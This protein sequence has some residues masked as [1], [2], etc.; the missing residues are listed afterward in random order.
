[1]RCLFKRRQL[2]LRVEMQLHS[3]GKHQTVE[4]EH[5]GYDIFGHKNL[6]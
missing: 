2:H 4:V 1:M 6:I 3:Q 5:S